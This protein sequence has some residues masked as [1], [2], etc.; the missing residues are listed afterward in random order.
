MADGTHAHLY[1]MF[2]ESGER[3]EAVN[4]MQYAWTGRWPANRA[5]RVEGLRIDGLA[6]AAS[7]T[8]K[9][10]SAYTVPA[11]VNGI[12]KQITP[13]AQL[14]YRYL[15]VGLIGGATKVH[16][17]A[18]LSLKILGVKDARLIETVKIKVVERQLSFIFFDYDKGRA[19][20]IL[21]VLYAEALRYPFRE[22]GLARPQVPDESDDIACHKRLAEPCS[23]I[24]RLFNTF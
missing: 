23:D 18:K 24:Y 10:A 13:P 2:L 21:D 20:D 19:V 22:N 5:P 4:V 7:V 9:P 14:Q 6:A 11:V 17:M 15:P 8:L 3:T 1:G 12:P 16:P